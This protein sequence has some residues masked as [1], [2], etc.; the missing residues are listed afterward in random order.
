MGPGKHDPA[1]DSP[2]GRRRVICLPPAGEGNNFGTCFELHV[3]VT[4]ILP[5]VYDITIKEADSRRNRVFLFDGD[6]P[7]LIDA[8]FADTVDALFAG[9]DEISTEPERLVIT[10]G[11]PDHIEGFDAVVDRYAVETW[12]PEQTDT[13]DIRPPDNRYDDGETIGPF[14][15]IHAPGHEADNY[16]LIDEADGVLVA[17][18]ALFGADL[19]GLPSGHLIPPPA[20]YSENVNQAE[21]SLETLLEHEFESVLVFH[22]SSVT[23][24]AY[25]QLDAFVNFPGKPEWATY[26]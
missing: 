23:D 21:E 6:V 4:E 19:R 22:G 24:G 15:A 11:D 18:D 5:G 8:G 3:M 2:L 25:E 16:A 7:T 12:V 14:E 17:G 9:I 13:G 1:G 26:R 10:H 20:L